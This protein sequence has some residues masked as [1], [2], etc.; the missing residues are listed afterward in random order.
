[1]TINQTAHYACIILT[2]S[3]IQGPMTVA[4][5]NLLRN[6]GVAA[7]YTASHL[8]E[9]R[10][11]TRSDPSLLACSFETLGQSHTFD[12][13]TRYWL[14]LRCTWQVPVLLI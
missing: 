5:N 7:L 10:R 11:L 3:R 4:S 8:C 6:H 2:A 9:P 14:D 12:K 13:Q 1:M